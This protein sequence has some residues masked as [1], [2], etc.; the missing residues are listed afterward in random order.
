MLI[1]LE[2]L[3]LT[4]LWVVYPG[5]QAYELDDR[6]SVIPIADITCLKELIH[7]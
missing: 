1:V 6:I 5:D 7:S 3:Q 2:D 4:H